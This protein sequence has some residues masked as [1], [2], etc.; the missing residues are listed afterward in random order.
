MKNGFEGKPVPK[1]WKVGNGGFS[2]RKV[3]LSFR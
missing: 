1:M 3:V 2:L